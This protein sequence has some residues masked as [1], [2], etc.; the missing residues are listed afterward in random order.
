VK[1]TLKVP[2]QNRPGAFVGRFIKDLGFEK[3]FVPENVFRLPAGGGTSKFTAFDIT[4]SLP[5]DM[6]G[7][8]SRSPFVVSDELKDPSL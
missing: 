6:V 7:E 3:G 1:F 2:Y 4:G 8:L 5:I